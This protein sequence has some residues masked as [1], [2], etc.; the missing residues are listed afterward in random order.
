MPTRRSF[1]SLLAAAG[2]AP[3]VARAQATGPGTLDVADRRGATPDPIRVFLH[4][5]AAWTPDRRIVVVMH[6][7]R[8]NADRYAEN[9]APLADEHGFLLVVP[10][11]DARKFPRAAFY[12][13]GGMRDEDGE[14]RPKAEWTFGV[15]DTVVDAVRR[16]FGA[17]RETFSLYGHSAGAQFVHR[18][19]MFHASPR[20]EMA[21]A[22]NAG[23]YTLPRFGERFP[24]GLDGTRTTPADHAA[25]LRRPLILQLGDRDTD[26]DHP[27]LR[28]NARADRQG[29][30]RFA[31]GEF[32]MAIAREEAAR[33][34]VPLAWKEHVTPGVGHS[35]AGMGRDAARL[36]FG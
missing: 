26:P 8:R 14:P 29:T 30:Y 34:G 25:M 5:P 27:A 36:L 35:D 6:G 10:E 11:F 9:W 21:V 32:M 4:R 12:N 1:V 15:I 28:R 31:R 23:W 17:T 22:A 18:F 2:V 20:L 16:H 24:Y 3:S 13:F 33:L 7:V 19:V